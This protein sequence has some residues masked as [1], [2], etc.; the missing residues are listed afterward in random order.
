[1][2]MKKIFSLMLAFVC[3]MFVGVSC[4][5][6]SGQ[7]N[8]GGVTYTSTIN[9]TGAPE[10]N[11][12]PAAG[13]LSLG[14]SIENATLTDALVVTTEAAWV[15]V[16]EIGEATVAITYDANTDAPNSP[17]REAVIKFA[18]NGAAD[19][20]VTLKQDSAAPTFTVAFDEAT[21]T[22]GYASYTW[23]TANTEIT[24]ALLSTQDLG[25]FG[26]AGETPEELLTNYI[27][28][29]AG[30]GM[31]TEEYAEWGY[32][33]KGAPVEGMYK[34]AYRYDA[35]ESVQVY[36]VGFSAE[37]T[38]EIDPNMETPIFKVTLL[39]PVHVWDVP[40]KPYPTV[41]VAE[42]DMTK[43]VTSAAGEIVI[44]CVVENP[45]E[46]E[47]VLCQTEAAWV[48]PSWADNK[49]TLAYEANTAAVAR[50]AKIAVQYGYYTNPFEITLVQEKD[51][52]AVATT[53][54]VKVT[55]TTFNG[56]WVDV[57]P[58]DANALY[59]LD[60]TT[61]EKNWETGAEVAMDWA[62]VAENLLSY[63]PGT[64]TFH[65]GELKGH[66]IKMNP[67][68]YEWYG[69]DYYVY[70]V[71]VDATSEEGTDWQG[72]PKTTWTVN[73][74]LSD[75]YYDR[76]TIDN[77]KTPSVEWDLTKNP[78]LVWNESAERYDLEVVE[79]TTVVLNFIVNNPADGAFLALNGTSLY[80][81]YNVVDG[82]PVVDNAAG[83]VT[84]KI[85]KFD[86]SKKY[87]YV[88]PSFKYTNAEGDTWGITTPTLRLTQV[89]APKATEL[90]I[91]P[92]QI[93]DINKAGSYYLADGTN[94]VVATE[95]TWLKWTSLGINLEA[96]RVM[97]ST[98][99]GYQGLFQFQGDASN[100]EKQGFLGN[101]TSNGE[102]KQVVV[103]AYSTYDTPSFNL[104]YGD[105]KLPKDSAKV[106]AAA[107][108][109]V[110]GASQGMIGSY[111]CFT[112]TCTFEVP[113]GNEY[114]AVRNDSKGAT[115]IKS[116]TVKY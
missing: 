30:Y 9:V 27:S 16:G 51:A 38:G 6:D 56:I 88:S 52:N 34:E 78:E 12:A 21:L 8:N 85:D 64:T 24:Y 13:E 54:E 75:V 2:F 82:E 90:V 60:T 58:S 29:L 25:Q 116:I 106:L 110:K 37:D 109:C 114:F 86:T 69:L 49:L 36:A 81:S 70:A 39:T 101:A 97:V 91:T 50:R 48:V 23:T 45:M 107:S 102:V 66:F 98:A 4:T 108:N 22:C 112:F 80:D 5:P 57:T 31:L 41:V 47:T 26:I 59:A 93:A 1:M 96:C 53:L 74:I 61:P 63:V 89:E 79:N 3:A 7:E 44:D 67:S 11:L 65:K 111:E 46:G 43:N 95:S 14:Y 18:Y 73:G 19:V 62:T 68:N 104:Y 115:Y 94:Q 77:S 105:A 71:A 113:A 40:F 76:T 42:A 84:I 55:G 20:L 28:T 10:A 15:H 35:K 99:D 32:W 92:D 17:A 103:E 72:N 83:T 87:H 100:V 33:Y